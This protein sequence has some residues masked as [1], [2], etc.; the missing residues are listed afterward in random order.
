[1]TDSPVC[2]KCK[3]KLAHMLKPKNVAMMICGHC[4]HEFEFEGAYR[5]EKK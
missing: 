3:K 2:P 1:M 4:G 5:N